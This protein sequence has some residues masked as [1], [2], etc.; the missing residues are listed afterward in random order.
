MDGFKCGKCMGHKSGRCL[1]RFFHVNGFYSILF[2]G[3]MDLSP[4]LKAV[5][6][7]V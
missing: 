3:Q 1:E 7:T 2:A 6:T 5:T 4:I